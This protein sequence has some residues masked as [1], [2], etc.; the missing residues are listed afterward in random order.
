MARTMLLHA[1]A[2]WPEAVHLSLWPYAM[3]TAVEIMNSMPRNN[4]GSSRLESFARIQIQPKMQHFHTFGCP[5]Y[6]LT[7]QAEASKVRKWDPKARVGLYLGPSP[8]HA[9]SV[10]LVLNLDTA[11]CSPRFN[12]AHD[13]FFETIRYGHTKLSGEPIWQRIAGLDMAD[14]IRN[15]ER[16]K[17]LALNDD[18]ETG[19]VL[20]EQRDSINH[21]DNQTNS[22]DP[23]VL[24]IIDRPENPEENPDFQAVFEPGE[25][26]DVPVTADLAPPPE[27][28]RVMRERAIQM[29]SDTDY[30][31][32][33][34]PR[35]TDLPSMGTSRY[36]RSRT[37]SR[38]LVEGME[39]GQ[40]NPGMLSYLAEEEP[41]DDDWDDDYCASQSTYET[42]HDEFLKMEERMR[43]PIAFS[44]EMMGDIMYFHQAMR[45]QDSDRFV[46]ALVKEVNAHVKHENWQVVPIEEK[47]EEEELIP[48][49][50]AMR[51]KRNLVTNEITKYKAR[52]NIHGGKQTLGETTGRPMPLWLPGLQSDSSSF[53]A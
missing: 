37:M 48:A 41:E 9:G 42:E 30:A 25:V 51:R 11:L 36:G 35:S 44:A 10:S 5:V 3:R 21:S 16:V 2:R 4:D 1:R 22:H 40:V 34:F 20:N 49:V 45:Q 23:Y 43:N 26:I 7:N 14:A 31:S 46:D 13:E 39:T 47:P 6:A 29:M 33:P 18:V 27:S 15:R 8:L 28:T 12:V 19:D 53:V 17:R 52:L 38:K 50:W 32:P 24:P